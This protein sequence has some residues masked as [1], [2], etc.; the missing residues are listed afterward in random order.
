MGVGEAG[1][2]RVALHSTFSSCRVGSTLFWT[3]GGAASAGL[4]SIILCIFS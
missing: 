4:V 1:V 3:L 2:I